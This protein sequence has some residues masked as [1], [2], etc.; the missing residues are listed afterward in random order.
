MENIEIITTEELEQLLK[1]GKKLELVDVREDEEVEQGMI[2]GAKHIRMGDI[3]ANMDYFDDEKEYIFIC[4]S[5]R[6][7][8]NVCYY[9]Q[10][11]GFKVRNMAGGMLE[12][13]GETK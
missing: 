13:K 7:S 12:W 10:D 1:E 8:E 6:R 5:G 2:P 4:R 3:P 9:M 11:Q